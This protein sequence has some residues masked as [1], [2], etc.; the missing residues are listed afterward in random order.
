M[1]TA[2]SRSSQ[3]SHN[4]QS[5]LNSYKMRL[6]E[7]IRV[8]SDNFTEIVKSAKIPTEERQLV[9]KETQGHFDVYQMKVRASNIVRAGESLLKLISELKTFVILNDFPSINENMNQQNT[10]LKNT[11][12]FLMEK[13]IEMRDE[14]CIALTELESEYYNS[15][16]LPNDNTSSNQGN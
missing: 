15:L 7:D 4:T 12:T 13:I 11:A 16:R 9:Q 2:G 3:L 5:L 8:M 6:Q 14:F 1:A 10:T